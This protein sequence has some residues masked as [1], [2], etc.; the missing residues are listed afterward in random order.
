M[1]ESESFLPI[2]DSYRCNGCGECIYVCPSGALGVIDGLAV[3][4]SPDAC[5]YCADCEEHC[6]QKAISLPYEIV[7]D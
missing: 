5:A 7:L 1:S 4:T 3:L 2:V 6:P